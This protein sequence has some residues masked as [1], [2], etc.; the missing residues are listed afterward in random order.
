MFGRW[1]E[2]RRAAKAARRAEFY[3][4]IARIEIAKLELKPDDLIVIRYDGHM[5]E[6]VAR[7]IREVFER[8]S[9]KTKRNFVVIDRNLD[10]QVITKAA[11]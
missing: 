10:V 9:G 3:S 4:T 2:K 11:A 8:A 1:L 7:R 6:T 5:S